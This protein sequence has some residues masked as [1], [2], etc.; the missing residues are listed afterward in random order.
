MGPGP[1]LLHEAGSTFN[2]WDWVP[3]YSVGLA[4]FYTVGLG[5]CFI[6]WD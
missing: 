2:Q 5:P 6:L 4:P 3:F 1:L